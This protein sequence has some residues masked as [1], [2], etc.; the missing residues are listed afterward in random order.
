MDA[1]EALGVGT[2]QNP[3]FLK[4]PVA[5][6][7]IVDQAAVQDFY[8]DLG[9][10]GVVVTQPYRGERPRTQDAIDPVTAY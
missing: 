2:A 9:L 4:E 3:G 8:R 1:D 10:E 6:V 7:Q 5:H